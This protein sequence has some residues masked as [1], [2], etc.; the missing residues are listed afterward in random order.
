MA[1]VI[2]TAS[3]LKTIGHAEE[4][5]V[6]E[7][8]LVGDARLRAQRARAPPRPRAVAASTVER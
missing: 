3:R 1:A 2:D 5:R 8:G 7:V 6:L 4:R